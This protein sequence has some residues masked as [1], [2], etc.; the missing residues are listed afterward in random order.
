MK[1][2][3]KQLRKLILE[4]LMIPELD[5]TTITDPEHFTEPANIMHSIQKLTEAAGVIHDNT[6]A[7]REKINSIL[8]RLSSIE[9]RLDA[10]K[11]V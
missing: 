5:K 7:N 11:Q 3:R 8:E 4:E 1:I 2:T 9:Q 10:I 6:A